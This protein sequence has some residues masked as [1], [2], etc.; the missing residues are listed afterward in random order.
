LDGAEIYGICDLIKK[1]NDTKK[2]LL[3]VSDPSGK[4]LEYLQSKKIIFNSNIFLISE[5]HDFFEIMKLSDAFIRNTTTDGDSLSI[6]EALFLGKLVFATDIVTRPENCIVYHKLQEINFEEA[7]VIN[8]K[9]HR[10]I[11]ENINV[12]QD[13]LRIYKYLD[14]TD[15]TRP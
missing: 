3:I 5:P 6:H 2:S 15:Y 8:Q 7:L 1:F 14:E 10:P 11:Y 13:L 12:V 9:I 4:Y